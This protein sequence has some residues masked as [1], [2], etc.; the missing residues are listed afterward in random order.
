M[1]MWYGEAISTQKGQKVYLYEQNQTF[2]TPAL[3]YAGSPG[4]GSVHTSEFAYVFGNLSHYNVDN[5]PF[6]PNTSDYALL[7]RESRSWSSFAALDSPSLV[8][9]QTLQGWGTAYTEK[10]NNHIYVIGG[11]Q[12]GLFAEANG[13]NAALNAEKLQERCAFLNAPDIIV[14]LGF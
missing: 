3:T 9:K 1:A 7:Q 12:E 8:G 10:G 11:G 14:Q 4:L 13:A 2:L 5:F 6:L